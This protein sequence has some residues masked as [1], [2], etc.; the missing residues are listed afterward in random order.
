VGTILST[1]TTNNGEQ[2]SNTMIF[3]DSPNTTS[4]VYYTLC[5]DTAT[6]NASSMTINRIRIT[7]EEA[8]NS[9]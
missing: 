9:N 8:N 6:S 7:L 5:S 2:A 4:A 1:F 3:L